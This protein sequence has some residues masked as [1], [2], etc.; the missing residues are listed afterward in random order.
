VAN[1][2]TINGMVQDG[3]PDGLA[4]IIGR[5][6]LRRWAGVPRP[7]DPPAIDAPAGIETAAL[8]LLYRLT[9]EP[10]DPLPAIRAALHWAYVLGQR[11]G[12]RDSA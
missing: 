10:D 5:A 9:H 12:G 2:G 11:R 7:Y 4:A 1:A 3:D 8:L 6:A